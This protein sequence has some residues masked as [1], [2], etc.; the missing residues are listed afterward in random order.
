LRNRVLDAA[1]EKETNEGGGKCSCK[2]VCS[3]RTKGGTSTWYQR[4]GGGGVGGGGEW[5]G[6]GTVVGPGGMG[7][8]CGGS[9]CGRTGGG[10]RGGEGGGGKVMGGVGQYRAHFRVGGLGR[11]HAS[12]H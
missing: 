8:C 12:D 3:G 6:G 10:G 9:G 2:N 11:R 7:V 5:W 4:G 1:Y